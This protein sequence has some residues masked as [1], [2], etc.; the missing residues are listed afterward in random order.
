MIIDMIRIKNRNS[1]KVTDLHKINGSKTI[2]K[3]ST[4]KVVIFND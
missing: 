2:T 4:N 3:I 1:Q